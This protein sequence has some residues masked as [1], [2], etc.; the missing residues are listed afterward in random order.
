MNDE[1]EVFVS[2]EQVLWNSSA[3]LTFQE[4]LMIADDMRAELV[5]EGDWEQLCRAVAGLKNIYRDIGILLRE[6][7][8][9]AARL[10]PEKTLSVDG[11]GYVERRT[12]SSRKWESESLL[13]DVCRQV[14][15][16]EGTGEIQPSRVVELIGV[17]KKIMP[18][19][20]SLGWRVTAL[21]EQ[22]IDPDDYS[23]IRWGRK[24]IQ[25]TQQKPIEGEE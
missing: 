7:E 5:R 23:D 22:G 13:M 3:A 8:E 9:D 14:L 12:A 11:L 16:P 18:I 20:G 25:I 10:M 15:D 24:S 19:T 2:P 6:C 17:L 21:R 4:A 1:L